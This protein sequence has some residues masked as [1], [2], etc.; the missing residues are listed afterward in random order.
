[1]QWSHSIL[2]QGLRNSVSSVA[3][4]IDFSS[5]S[6]IKTHEEVDDGL[7]LSKKKDETGMSCLTSVLQD[8]EGKG[9]EKEAALCEAE[10]RHYFI[11]YIQN[12]EMFRLMRL[13][14]SMVVAQELILC[15]L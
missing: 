5:R 12:L 14:N 1:M 2:L 9:G 4:E 15:W 7:H 13:I 10:F 3:K 8:Q 6:I 11:F